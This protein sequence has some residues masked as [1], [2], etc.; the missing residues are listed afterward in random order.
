MCGGN[1]NKIVSQAFFS[2]IKQAN[3]LVYYATKKLVAT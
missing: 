1:N 3:L 2:P